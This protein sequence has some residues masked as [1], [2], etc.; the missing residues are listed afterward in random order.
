MIMFITLSGYW[1]YMSL[2]MTQGSGDSKT[3]DFSI[4]DSANISNLKFISQEAISMRYGIKRILIRGYFCH[5]VMK[6]DFALQSLK[7]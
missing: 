6:Q 2:S 5:Q 3:F 1:V 4:P 7:K